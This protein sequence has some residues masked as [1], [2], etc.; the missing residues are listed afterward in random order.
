M[1]IKLLVAGVSASLVLSVSHAA[2][3]GNPQDVA[4]A[5]KLWQVM[6]DQRFAGAGAIQGTPYKGSPPHGAILD[7]IDGE[8]TVGDNTGVL[9][10]KRNYG[11]P[12]VSKGAVSNAPQDY[13]KAI[14]I[15]YKRNGYDPDNKDWFWVKYKPDGSLHVNGKNM[16]LAGQIAKGMPTGCLSCHVAASGGDLVFNSDRFAD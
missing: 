11:G 3:F 14:T 2:P 5:A 7:T 6:L 16:P 1:N 9:I 8:V 15:M 12:G 4:Y 10:V 13:L